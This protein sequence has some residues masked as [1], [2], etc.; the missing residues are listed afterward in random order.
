MISRVLRQS[1]STS[2]ALLAI[3]LLPA[4]LKAGPAS[5][6]E[7]SHCAAPDKTWFNAKVTGSAKVVS[8]CGSASLAEP[9]SWLEYRFGKIGHIELSFPQSRSGSLSDFTL[10]RYTRPR[11]TYLKFE[12]DNGGYNYAILEEFNA[13]YEPHS[14][15]QLRVRGDSHGPDIH[16]FALTM[17]TPPLSLMALEPFVRKAPFN[18]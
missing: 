14:A 9:T 4:V 12:F 13:D 6:V 18:E 2:M 17:T 1:V 16:N 8:I 3:A 11:T 7:P 15:A 5:A 10:R